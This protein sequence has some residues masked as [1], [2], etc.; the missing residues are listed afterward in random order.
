MCFFL[1]E[2]EDALSKYWELKD[3]A[4]NLSIDEL[5]QMKKAYIS[6]FGILSLQQLAGLTPTAFTL[7]YQKRP[8]CLDRLVKQVKITTASL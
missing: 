5:S 6:I 1:N 8:G 2:M 3:N 7:L 4:Q